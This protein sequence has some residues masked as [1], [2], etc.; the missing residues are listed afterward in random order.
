VLS[1]NLGLDLPSYDIDVAEKIPRR[2]RFNIFEIMDVSDISVLLSSHKDAES[3][4]PGTMLYTGF[5][6][7]AL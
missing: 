6:L 4:R 2:L 3:A 7:T 5:A 1:A